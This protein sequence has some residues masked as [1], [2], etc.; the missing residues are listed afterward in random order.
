MP[1]LDI[2]C[3]S[4]SPER[5]QKSGKGLE[6]GNLGP[7]QPGV[8]TPNQ[9]FA[10]E[11][12]VC[13]YG[14]Y[15]FILQASFR[16]SVWASCSRC[17]WLPQP[18]HL[19]AES[20]DPELGD[21][22]HSLISFHTVPWSKARSTHVTSYPSGTV[23]QTN[24]FPPMPLLSMY[25]C[26]VPKESGN[27]TAWYGRMTVLPFLYYFQEGRNRTHARI[28]FNLLDELAWWGLKTN[29]TSW[30]DPHEEKFLGGT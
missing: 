4:P 28:S 25:Q 10:A 1:P 18:N 26:N 5:V 30:W 8:Q 29:S 15:F 21:F 6:L 3:N 23:P 11:V 22:V 9:V 20:H 13:M 24:P 27:L 16:H 19:K 12:Y 17:A 14:H 2:L 7:R